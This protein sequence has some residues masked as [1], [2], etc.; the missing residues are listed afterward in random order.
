MF[1]FV[2]P[3]FNSHLVINK[4]VIVIAPVIFLFFAFNICPC[5]YS[6]YPFIHR[7]QSSSLLS[8]MYM[9]LL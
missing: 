3:K 4:L 2:L 1:I 8:S 5:S 6:F 7:Y 9:K